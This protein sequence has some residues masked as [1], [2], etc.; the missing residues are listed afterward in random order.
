MEETA[1][2]VSNILHD[3]MDTRKPVTNITLSAEDLFDGAKVADWIR[4][5]LDCDGLSNLENRLATASSERLTHAAT[6]YLLGLAV[7]EKLELNFDV[8]PR[9]FSHGAIGD[10]FHFFWSAICLCH[11]LGYQYER[12][13]CNLSLMDSSEGRCALLEV[14]RDLF[15]LDA[16]DLVSLG[17]QSGSEREWVLFSLDLAKKYDRLRRRCDEDDSL[18]G[19][20]DH[21]IAGALILYD[22]LM[23]EYERFRPKVDVSRRRDPSKFPIVHEGELPTYAGYKRF[24]ACAVIIACTVARHNMWIAGKSDTDRYQRYGLSALCEGGSA[25]RIKGDDMMEQ[26]LFLLG[27]MDT[28]DPV[29]GIYVRKA[30][31]SSQDPAD[32]TCHQVSL[33]DDVFIH[34]QAAQ[35]YRWGTTLRYRAFTISIA[36]DAPEAVRETFSL[37]ARGV[38]GM[39]DWL[40]TRPPTASQDKDGRTISVTCYYPTF[41]HRE[42]IWA[43]G[44]LEHEVTALCLYAGGGVGKAGFFYQCRNAYQT[45]NLLMMDGFVGEEVRVRQEGQRPYS[46]YILE[47]QHTLEILVDILKAQNKFMEYDRGNSPESYTLCRVD[48]RVN[49]DMMCHQG[50]TFAFTSTSKAGF[51]QELARPKKELVLLNIVL[52]CPVPFVDYGRLLGRAY[53]YADEQEVLLPPFL[54]VLNLSEGLL[55]PVDQKH[56]SVLH[57]KALREYTVEL[58]AFSPGESDIDEA[59]L[60]EWLE[61][62]KR[63]AATALDRFCE[64]CVLSEEEKAVYLGWKKRF[65]QLVRSCFGNMQKAFLMSGKEV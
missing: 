60:I 26:L 52:T 28:I 2:S 25:A 56:F 4:R 39:A 42:R 55:S 9:I 64:G 7:R 17:I 45:F 10:A 53:V 12:K 48:R 63:L 57:A 38:V 51:L 27:F 11:D 49:F 20:V 36:P 3:M 58:G 35:Q 62:N 31:C 40:D 59:A 15:E 43:G 32:L 29:K 30:E 18:D 22:I 24:A 46:C 34:F 8:L 50:E 54:S 6:A 61:T 33:L 23:D 44:I 47:W 13:N 37:Y 1:N 65:Q 41:P 19:V 16:D 21:G 14:H 5:L